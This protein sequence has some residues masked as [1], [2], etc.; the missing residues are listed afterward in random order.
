MSDWDAWTGR[1]LTQRDVLTPALLSR[2]RATLDSRDTGDIA[3]QG[4]HWCLST[5]DA[6]TASLGADGH[7]LRTGSPDSFLPPVPLPRR[8]WASS[9][10][11]FHA[12]IH[13]GQ[14]TERR[15]T[16][17][18][19]TAKSGGSG[20]LVFAEIDHLVF[21]GEVL[22]VTERQT[23]VYRGAATDPAAP[24]GSGAPA[25]ADWQWH[26]EITPNEALLFRYSA[27]TFNSHRIHYDAPYAADE[28]GY[29]GIVVHGPLTATL[30]LNLAARELGN[31]ALRQFSFRGQSPAYAGEALHLVGRN[32][33]GSIA[34]AALGSDGRVVMSASGQVSN[35]RN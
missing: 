15:S 8:M 11:V 35:D 17:A 25:L 34:M 16:L 30:L 10:V 5:P 22:A 4:L 24:L 14:A 18:A 20:D 31:N 28:E 3:P 27:L 9:A 21:A 12:P 7:P 33:G 26:R 1:T 32:D 6:P 2:F 29:R 13:V 19:I 23:L